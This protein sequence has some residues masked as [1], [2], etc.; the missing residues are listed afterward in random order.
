LKINCGLTEEVLLADEQKNTKISDAAGSPPHDWPWA[1]PHLYSI[2]TVP[3][4]G[5]DIVGYSAHKDGT[6]EARIE[7]VSG[8]AR[9]ITTGYWRG[10]YAVM[11]SRVF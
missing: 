3:E 1:L 6:G 7:N 5:E 2:D 10:Q 9:V 11:S 8:R 4:S